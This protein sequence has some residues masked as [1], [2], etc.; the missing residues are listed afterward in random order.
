MK[1]YL[2]FL[3]LICAYNTNAQSQLKVLTYNI[4]H[5]ENPYKKGTP[6]LDDVAA[7]INRIKPDVVALQEVD[8]ATGRLEKIYGK[9][10]NW[11]AELAKKTGMHGYFGK[12]MDFDGGGYGEAILTRKPSKHIVQIL[13]NP[14]GGE[15]R[16]IVY[17][18]VIA[19]KNKKLLFA[20]THLCHQFLPN[21]MAQVQKIDEIMLENKLPA[22]ICGDFNFSP[23]EEPY[24][25]LLQSWTDAAVVFGDPQYSFPA[26]DPEIRIDYIWMNKETNWKVKEV[27]VLEHDFS[28]HRPVL[29]ILEL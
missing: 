10:I 23:G 26:D 5:G 4:F 13:P 9:R 8:S 20:G 1:F 12:A 2:G 22:V 18:Q 15:P 14:A 11:V 27:K 28:D 17:A 16:S 21:K 29:A 19:G 3:M 25:H 24:N 7:L 6:N